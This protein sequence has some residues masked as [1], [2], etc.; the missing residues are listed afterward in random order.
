MLRM[1]EIKKKDAEG[2]KFLVRVRFDERIN[3]LRVDDVGF[4][5]KG[6]RKVIFI[7]ASITNDYGWRAL[8]WEGRH[9]AT[10]AEILKYTPKE[11]LMEA[12]IEAWEQTKPTELNF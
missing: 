7:G 5:P 11:L 8:T 4:T 3:R 1:W 2:N 9:E 6:K 10:V 12:L